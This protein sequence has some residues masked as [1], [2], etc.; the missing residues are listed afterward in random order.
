MSLPPPFTQETAQL[1]VKKAQDLW[2]TQYISSVVHRRSNS[3]IL[4]RNPEAVSKAYTP[5]SIWRNRM[6]FFNGTAE[7][8]SFLTWKWEKERNY[9]LRKELFAFQDNK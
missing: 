8:V 1:K 6:W 9:K 4:C 3:D 5:D 2:N 7:I